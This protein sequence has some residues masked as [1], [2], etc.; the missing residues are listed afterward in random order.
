MSDVKT[1]NIQIDELKAQ[2]ESLENKLESLRKEHK[3][4][5]VLHGRLHKSVHEIFERMERLDRIENI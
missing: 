1:W 4:L 2:I 5:F 3:L